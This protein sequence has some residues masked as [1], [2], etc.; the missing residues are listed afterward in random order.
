MEYQQGIIMK[1]MD[2]GRIV[3]AIVKL[4]NARLMHKFKK[5]NRKTKN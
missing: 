4:Q 3:Y 5:W 1:G 2:L